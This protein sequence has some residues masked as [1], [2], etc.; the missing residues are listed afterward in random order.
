[1]K[2][3]Y[4][5]QCLFLALLSSLF[6]GCVIAP[7]IGSA[8]SAEAPKL[9]TDKDSGEPAWDSPSKF[10]PVPKELQAV[11]DEACANVNKK[12]KAI[13]FHPNAVNLQGEKLA[14]GGYY[15]FNK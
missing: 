13:G 11:G 6:A 14:G 1:M 4:L 8:P 12:L 7:H 2:K 3:E 15:C 9:I 5:Y 10:G